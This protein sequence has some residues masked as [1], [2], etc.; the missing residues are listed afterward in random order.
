M[1]ARSAFDIFNDGDAVSDDT[2]LK[3]LDPSLTHQES[4]IDTDINRIV[5]TWVR[6]GV[7]PQTSISALTGDFTDALDY[8][9]SLDR[10]RAAQAEF[11]GL[12]A[13]VRSYFANDPAN[14]IDF[15]SNENN[16]SKAEELGLVIKP[17]VSP[18]PSGGDEGVA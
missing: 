13:N 8:R 16:R 12:E 6:T 7:A 3:C 10:L 2:G 14:L 5:E 17:R 1:K 4:L 15:L 11:N 18:P 9:G